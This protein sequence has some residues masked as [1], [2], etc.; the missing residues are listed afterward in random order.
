[1]FNLKQKF[2]DGFKDAILGVDLNK[3]KVPDALQSLNKIDDGLDASVEFLQR[4]DAADYQR[5]LTLANIYLLPEEKRYSK[6]EIIKYSQRMAGIDE[7]LA[8]LDKLVEHG[9]RVVEAEIK[10]KKK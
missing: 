4:F 5:I 3:D 10:A 7:G 1:M 8:A 9:E 2:F 6:E